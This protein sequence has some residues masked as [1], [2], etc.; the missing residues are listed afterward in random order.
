MTTKFALSRA[1]V[2]A[3]LVVSLA[4]APRAAACSLCR[5]GD[6][7]FTL[8]G[9]QIFSPVRWRFGFDTERFSK[10]QVAEPHH[11]EHH[12]GEIDAARREEEV[13]RRY[14]LSATYSAGRRLTLVA[15]VPF[16]Q[17]TITVGGESERLS[18]LSDPELLVHYRVAHSARP[19]S[20]L[21]LTAG[22]R[23]RWGA[24]D[25]PLGGERAEEHLQP[26]SGAAGATAGAAFATLLGA[27]T[28]LFGS[29]NGRINGRND[30][31]YRY[32]GAVLANLALERRLVGRVN[33]IVELN[34]RWAARDE[35]VAGERDENSGGSV[36]YVS[37]RVLLQ[38]DPR[39]NLW[40]RLGAQIPVAKGLYGDQDEKVNLLAGLTVRF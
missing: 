29:L 16:A 31:G 17:R 27:E 1:L 26:G 28:S 8:V 34:Y 12:E 2:G 33:G 19:G 3:S 24:N 36:L 6:P 14:T 4:A 40:L 30:A 20:W 38:L 11:D 23:S 15:R 13:E 10:D 18:G 21:A 7:A 37:P 9:S 39:Q 35:V 5:C 32:G 25:K 22:V